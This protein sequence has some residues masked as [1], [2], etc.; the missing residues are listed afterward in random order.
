MRGIA[1]LDEQWCI[2]ARQ[3]LD[4]LTK[5]LGGFSRLENLA[6]QMVRDTKN[7]LRVAESIAI[8][9]NAGLMRVV[10]RTLCSLAEQ[11][12][13]TLMRPYCCTHRFGQRDM[14]LQEVP[15]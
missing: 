12:S 8:V 13:W 14:R 11:T 1:P 7:I 4:T 3:R 5:P 9:S 15:G 2:C 6:A 10:L